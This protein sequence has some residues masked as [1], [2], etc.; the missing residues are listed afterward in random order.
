MILSD[1]GC[2]LCWACLRVGLACTR[3]PRAGW[4]GLLCGAAGLCCGHHSPVG[5][6]WGTGGVDVATH[7]RVGW[8]GAGPSRCPWAA[9][10]NV[11]TGG[12]P[13]GDPTHVRAEA[14]AV[15]GS[16]VCL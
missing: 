13:P 15:A 12:P 8:H 9:W 11:P 16:E 6:A 1:S 7:L 10:W 14:Q 5:L 2:V 3:W 4:R